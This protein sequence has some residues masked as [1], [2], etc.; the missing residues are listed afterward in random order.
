MYTQKTPS[1][2]SDESEM[3]KIVTQP[4]RFLQAERARTVWA[5]QKMQQQE[6]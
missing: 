1:Q 6:T 4:K 3:M 5:G 2:V